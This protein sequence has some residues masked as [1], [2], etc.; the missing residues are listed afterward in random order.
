MQFIE[1]VMSL[2]EQ[3]VSDDRFMMSRTQSTI[4]FRVT[5]LEGA[6]GRKIQLR[7]LSSWLVQ[8]LPLNGMADSKFRTSV[9]F[10][11]QSD[12]VVS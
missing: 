2:A 12:V 1:I 7:K 8:L 4:E 9:C 11:L 5:T 6:F 10:A 3:A